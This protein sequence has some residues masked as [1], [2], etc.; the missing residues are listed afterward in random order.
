M[1]IGK[2]IKFELNLRIISGTAG[3]SAV[4]YYCE[5][6]VRGKKGALSR[7]QNRVTEI[8]NDRLNMPR[9]HYIDTPK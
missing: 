8:N 3:T 7:M 5:Y 4:L 1:P 2:I 6:I 9:A